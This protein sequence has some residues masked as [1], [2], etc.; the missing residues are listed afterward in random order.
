MLTAPAF[1]CPVWVPDSHAS[2]C[3]R[4]TLPF[5]Y[6]C[7]MLPATGWLSALV[8]YPVWQCDSKCCHPLKTCQLARQLQLERAA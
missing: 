2:A 6:A 5:R 8:A 4:C 7:Q 3:S 1:Q